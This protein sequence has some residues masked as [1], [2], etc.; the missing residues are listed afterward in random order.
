MFPYLSHVPLAHVAAKFKLELLK[1]ENNLPL[2][3]VVVTHQVVHRLFHNTYHTGWASSAKVIRHRFCHKM[4]QRSRHTLEAPFFEMVIARIEG[5]GGFLSRFSIF[6]LLSS[7]FKRAFAFLF[8]GNT[9]LLE[10]TTFGVTSGLDSRW[11]EE[12]NEQNI[13]KHGFDFADRPG[14]LPKRLDSS[15]RQPGGI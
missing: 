6:H 7:V 2:A 11:D 1:T 10:V 14:D 13:R 9:R 5:F 8:L 15:N 3:I 4:P 12:K